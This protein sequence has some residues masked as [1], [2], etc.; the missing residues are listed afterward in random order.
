MADDPRMPPNPWDDFSPPKNKPT[1]SMKAA[2][3]TKAPVDKEGKKTRRPAFM[4][5]NPLK[6]NPIAKGM[7]E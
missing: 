1:P 2:V 3:Q 6:A 5:A 7:K 4:R